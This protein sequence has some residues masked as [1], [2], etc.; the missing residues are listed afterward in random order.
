MKKRLACIIALVLLL[1][2]ASSAL[3]CTG[4]IVGKNASDNG[5]LIVARNEDIMNAYNKTFFVNP[6]TTGEGTTTVVDEIN[7]FTWEVPAAGMSWTMVNDV[8]EHGDGLYPE[9]CLNSA[10]VL[11]SASFAQSINDE[12]LALDP[13]TK[14]GLRQAYLPN[15]VAPFAKT[16]KEAIQ[17]LAEVI[18]E[19]G[20]AESHIIQVADANEAWVMELLSGHQWAAA[21]VPDDQF[22]II[23]NA[24]ILGYVDADDTENFLF[25]EGLFTMPEEAGLLKTHND[26]PHV[27]LT[28][29]KGMN[30]SS[31]PRYWAGQNKFAGSQSIAF[32]TEVFEDFLTPDA[33]ISLYDVMSMLGYRYEGTE[34][35][36]N[37]SGLRAIGGDS[38]VESHV[39]EY[40]TNGI[41]TGWL[42]LGSVEDNVFLPF[43]SA[44]SETPDAFHVEGDGYT[45]ESAYWTFKGMTTLAHVSREFAAPAVKAYWAGYQQDLIKQ[46]SENDAKYLAMDAAGQETYANELFAGIAAD[47]LD[48]ATQISHELIY[49]LAQNSSMTVTPKKPFAISFQADAE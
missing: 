11:I 24:H 23:A 39:F 8:P 48:K 46:M 30:D 34:Y 29:G 2:T 9:M 7:G 32:D 3:A 49:Y 19:K 26:Q 33:P 37:L 43:Y 47:A 21:K 42:A 35:D 45:P 27:A 18:A 16:A 38:T 44:L 1:G 28:Y 22:I 40:K 4:I 6:A 12:I 14:D 36:A 15:T 10:G 31:R 41:I 13:F 25:S 20:N 5:S 17:L